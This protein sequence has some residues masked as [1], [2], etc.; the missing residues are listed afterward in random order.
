M[1]KYPFYFPADYDF[2]CLKEEIKANIEDYKSCSLSGRNLTVLI[3]HDIYS[4][5]T[6]DDINAVIASYDVNQK[7]LEIAINKKCNEI[8]EYRERVIYSDFTYDNDIFQGDRESQ[9][10]LE[11]TIEANNTNERLRVADPSIDA[12]SIEWIIKNNTK[13]IIYNTDIDA[14]TL[15]LM[16][17]NNECKINAFWHKAIVFSLTDIDDIENY[18]FSAGWPA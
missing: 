10:S 7:N 9:E 6:F 18:D 3:N 4:Q 15:L 5:S 2:E 16:N 13:K 12:F 1:I 8:T 17:K 11:H 14:I